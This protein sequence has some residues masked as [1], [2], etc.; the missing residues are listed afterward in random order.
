MLSLQPVDIEGG[1]GAGKGP[2]KPPF[3]GLKLKPI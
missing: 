3:P 1:G 2:N